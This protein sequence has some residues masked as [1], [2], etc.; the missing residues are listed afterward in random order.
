MSTDTYTDNTSETQHRDHLAVVIKCIVSSALTRHC[1]T[2]VLQCCHC[3][4][5]ADDGELEVDDSALWMGGGGFSDEGE[6]RESGGEDERADGEGGETG[7]EG[8][9]RWE[10]EKVEG[11]DVVAGG[12]AVAT[13]TGAQTDV[14]LY[15]TLHV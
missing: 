13:V 8:D 6:E 5:A 4:V 15:A 10:T 12:Y 9:E 2:T 7:R 3:D 11:G 14:L 1:S